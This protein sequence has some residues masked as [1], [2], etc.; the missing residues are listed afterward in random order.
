MENISTSSIAVPLPV[1]LANV[2]TPSTTKGK[3]NTIPKLSAAEASKLPGAIAPVVKKTETGFIYSILFVFPE[4]APGW[5]AIEA[6]KVHAFAIQLDTQ[7]TAKGLGGVTSVGIADGS[8]GVTL[9]LAVS[10]NQ[11]SNGDPAAKVFA[12]LEDFLGSAKGTTYKAKV[13]GTTIVH[14]VL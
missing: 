9:T 2:T 7:A 4:T 3:R 8:F 6:N 13:N 10:G 5:S 1:P 12:E 11:T 14:G